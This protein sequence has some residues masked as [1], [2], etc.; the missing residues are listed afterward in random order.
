MPPPSPPTRRAAVSALLTL[1]AGLAPWSGR[2]EA[3]DHVVD[4]TMN[5]RAVLTALQ[6]GDTV[7]LLPGRYTSGLPVQGIEGTAARPILIYGPA[8]G[9]RAVIAGRSCCNTL[10]MRDSAWVT[11]RDVDFDGGGLAVDAI[12]LES[13]AR[14]AHHIT[15]E[16]LRITNHDGSQ[17]AVGISTKAPAWDWVIRGVR[18]EGA[19]TGMYLGDS[20]GSA[21]FVRGL[22]EHVTILDTIGYNIEIKHQTG[23]P[24]LAGLPTTPSSTLIR[25]S[26][27][28][29]AANASQGGSG[30]PNVLVGHFPRTGAGRDDRYEIYGNFFY[31]NE[32]LA[33][34]LFQGEGNLSFHDNLLYNEHGGAFLSRPHNDVPKAIDVYHNTIVASGAGVEIWGADTSAAQRVIANAIY[35]SPPIDHADGTNRDNTTGD[36][37]AARA[38]LRAPSGPVGGTLDLRPRAGQLGGAAVDLSAFARDQDT[39]LDFDRNPR[40]GT[41]RGAYGPGGANAYWPL[42]LVERPGRPQPPPPLPTDAGVDIDAGSRPDAG[43]AMDAATPTDAGVIADAGAR[44]DAAVTPDAGFLVDAGST[45]MDAGSTPDAGETALDAGTAGPADVGEAAPSA[46]RRNTSGGCRCVG[47][48]EAGGARGWSALAALVLVGAGRRRR[49]ARAPRRPSTAG[50]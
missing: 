12:K 48:D 33:Q 15:L 17:Q 38:A 31:Q 21:P 8:T 6:P 29:K 32:A 9:P 13:D 41:M 11:V 40:D 30:R 4:P 36:A 19:G 10:S 28:S 18:I 35:A 34:T 5:Y 1:L 44:R 16:G 23:R 37:A 49:A 43:V 50:A 7:R 26:V 20:D 24:N 47:G 39:G 27:F 22:I 46:G 42:A 2:A 45:P 3:A 25:Y 14:F